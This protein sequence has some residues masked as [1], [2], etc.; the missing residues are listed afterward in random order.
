MGQG[1]KGAMGQ[2]RKGAMGQ[3]KAPRSP[4]AKRGGLML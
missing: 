3:G 1:R 2:G 4:T